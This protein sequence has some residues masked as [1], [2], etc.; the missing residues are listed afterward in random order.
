MSSVSQTEVAVFDGKGTYPFA[1][2]L[3]HL[4]FNES[5]RENLSYQRYRDVLGT[6]SL[7]GSALQAYRY[8]IGILD[9][10]GLADYLLD[11]LGAALAYRHSAERAVARV[12]IGTQYHLSASREVFA[13]IGMYHRKMRGN[14]YAAVFFS[15]GQ[16]VDV[17]VLVYSAAHR[18]KRVVAVR[19]H[20]RD[21]ET[22]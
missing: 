3:H 9:V 22:L 2:E 19:Q 21:G 11:E 18:A 14:V 10:V 16:T 7:F 13:H 6:Y 5:V 8:Y 4:V 17:V 1:H 12:G 20:V 15:G